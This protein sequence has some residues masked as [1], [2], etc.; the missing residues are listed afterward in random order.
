MKL[1]KK[2][3]EEKELTYFYSYK[4]IS[5]YCKICTNIINKENKDKNKD[6]IELQQKEYRIKSKE[7]KRL[8]N[9]LN[10]ERIK[11]KS[12]EYRELNK[13]II[14]EKRKLYRIKNKDKINDYR[15]K[16]LLNDPLF[17]LSHTIRNSIKNSIKKQGYSKKS[18]TYIILGCSYEFFKTYIEDKFDEKMS[19]NNH[20]NYWHLDHIIPISWAKDE[21]ELYKLNHY[22]NFQ[23]LSAIQNLS[24]NNNYA[25]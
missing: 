14:Y 1:C 11:E 7:H 4:R 22:T 17:K 6:K 15:K 24:K 19:W 21:E 5:T 10:K 3:N 23:P 12:R 9:F 16:K 13:D 25:G 20:G 18:K 8:Y 2:C